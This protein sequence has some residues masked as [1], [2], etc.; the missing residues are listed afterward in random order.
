MVS[1]KVMLCQLSCALEWREMVLASEA[2]KPHLY[3]LFSGPL[4]TVFRPTGWEGS[5]AEM[6]EIVRELSLAVGRTGSN[7]QRLSFPSLF[8]MMTK[9][10][11]ANIASARETLRHKACWR[12][13][14]DS[15]SF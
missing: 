7:N 8:L 6:E 4:P 11:A 1:N 13:S 12:A 14:C 10:P 9:S 15:V 5:K 3:Q 2:W